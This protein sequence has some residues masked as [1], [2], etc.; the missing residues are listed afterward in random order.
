[1]EKKKINKITRV[2]CHTES[3]LKKVKLNPNFPNSICY[4][5]F[6]E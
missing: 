6:N 5:C 3:C 4:K 2:K 1:M